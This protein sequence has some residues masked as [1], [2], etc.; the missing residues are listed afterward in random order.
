MAAI[1]MSKH[2]SKDDRA[3]VR[4]ILL[5]EW[6]PIEINASGPAD[7]YDVYADRVYV[8]LMDKRAAAGDMAAYL[9]D[10]AIGKMGLPAGGRLAEKS[11]RAARLLIN[12]RSKFGA[13]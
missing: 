4:Q 10:V 11:D 5:R 3:R 13:N 6:D 9:I 12:L 8:M 2:Q 1:D 7:E